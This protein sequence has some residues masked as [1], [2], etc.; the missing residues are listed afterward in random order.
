MTELDI[1]AE[2]HINETWT[3]DTAGRK[4]IQFEVSSEMELTDLGD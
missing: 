1:A 4:E 3:I 2:V